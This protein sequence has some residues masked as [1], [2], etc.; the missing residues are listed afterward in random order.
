MAEWIKSDG[1]LGTLGTDYGGLEKSV[2]EVKDHRIVA[3]LIIL[4]SFGCNLVVGSISAIFHL[5][6]GLF[7]DTIQVLMKPIQKKSHEFL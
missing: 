3:F 2:E 5:N 4:P 7:L 1:D 6:I